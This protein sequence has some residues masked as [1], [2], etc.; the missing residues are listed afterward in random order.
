MAMNGVAVQIIVPPMVLVKVDGGL[1]SQMWQYALGL[2]V[3][4]HSP[5]EVRHDLSWFRNVAK[6]IQGK[7]NRLFALNNIFKNVRLRL[8][9]E[10]DRRFFSEY[11]NR[12]PGTRAAFE[13]EVL[14]QEQPSY[15]GGYYVNARYIASAAQ[16]VREAYAF[17]PV[18]EGRNREFL[19]QILSAEAPVAVHVRRGDFVGSI[20]EVITPGYFKQAFKRVAAAV[21]PATPTFFVFSNGMDWAKKEFANEPYS[22]VFVEGNEND[23]VAHDLFLMTQCKHFVIANSTLSW[24]GAWLSDR[25]ENKV[26]I[27][28]ELWLGGANAVAAASMQAPGWQVCPA[29]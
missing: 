29:G 22:F 11:L 21:C 17:S 20:H 2:A 26:V 19:H 10:R 25:A 7:E 28:P 3:E 16:E 23:D 18:M 9:A 4:K 14:T 13:P 12:F 27:M 1:G 5:F 15:L 8:P 24:W 6:D